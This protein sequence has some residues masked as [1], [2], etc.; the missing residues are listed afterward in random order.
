MILFAGISL[1]LSNWLSVVFMMIPV[2][3]GFIYRIKV[4]EK[5]MKDQFGEK[6]AEYQK[7]TKR[8]LPGIY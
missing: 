8:L 6:Y 3:F 7:R 2:S 5:F 4:E 1:S